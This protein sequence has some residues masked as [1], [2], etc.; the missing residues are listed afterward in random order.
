M[1]ITDK[2]VKSACEIIHNNLW[3]FS[4]NIHHL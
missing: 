3:Q 4:K 1:K 2:I